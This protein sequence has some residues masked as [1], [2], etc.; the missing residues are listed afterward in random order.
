MGSASAFLIRWI[1]FFTMVSRGPLLPPFASPF[2]HHLRV[3][4]AVFALLR[5]PCLGSAIVPSLPAILSRM[6]GRSVPVFLLYFH[7]RRPIMLPVCRRETPAFWCTSFG[8][9]AAGFTVLISG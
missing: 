1:N 3:L 2:L 8:S 7:L 5:M 4:E 6:D 9:P